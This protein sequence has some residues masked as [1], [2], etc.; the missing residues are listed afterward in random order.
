MPTKKEYRRALLRSM[1]VES[2]R[3]NLR[4]LLIFLAVTALVLGV[5]S[6]LG[7]IRA[8]NLPLE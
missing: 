4:F 7:F 6:Y 2:L 3:L 5:T 1:E 8:Q